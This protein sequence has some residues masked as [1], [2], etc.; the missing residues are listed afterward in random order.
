MNLA[1]LGARN[2]LWGV[3]SSIQV[4]FSRFL[5]MGRPAKYTALPVQHTRTQKKHFPCLKFGARISELSSKYGM[6]SSI[7]SE[8]A[9]ARLG[10]FRNK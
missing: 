1:S 2:A 9:N 5:Y 10:S 4:Q 7:A 6:A 3:E 8:F